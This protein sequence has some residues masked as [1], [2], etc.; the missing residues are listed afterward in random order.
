M[1]RSCGVSIGTYVCV[2]AFG[3]ARTRAHACVVVC[4]AG[5]RA[6]YSSGVADTRVAAIARPYRVLQAE[7]ASTA[8]TAL[9]CATLLSGTVN[10]SPPGG[11]TAPGIA[12]AIT[13]L[14]SMG[15]TPGGGAH[16]TAMPLV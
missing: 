12:D 4:C 5:I 11:S 6:I 7:L 3:R 8:F 13:I 1:P 9:S 15:S 16:A 14:P 2:F 10:T